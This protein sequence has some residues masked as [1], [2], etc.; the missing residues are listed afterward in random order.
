[1]YRDVSSCEQYHVINS[2]HPHVRHYCVQVCAEMSSLVSIVPQMYFEG[3]LE[4]DKRR[5][6]SKISLI[7]GNDPFGKIV[8]GDPLA[9]LSQS[10][11][12][13]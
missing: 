12:V 3:L 5:Y 11:H 6:K 8:G 13:I 1:M 7:D 2:V 4:E 10:T 9:E